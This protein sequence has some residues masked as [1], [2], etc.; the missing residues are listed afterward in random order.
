MKRAWLPILV[1]MFIVC[2]GFC[3]V[4]AIVTRP[5]SP[6]PLIV[7]CPSTPVDF[8]REAWAKFRALVDEAVPKNH[9]LTLK[10]LEECEEQFKRAFPKGLP[11]DQ[12]PA[13]VLATATGKK[14]QLYYRSTTGPHPVVEW[15]WDDK[16]D[17]SSFL[18]FIGECTGSK[19]LV[20]GDCYAMTWDW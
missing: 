11:L 2:G 8:D 6:V 5:P 18:L 10:R 16:L 7:N 9:D 12:I 14:K 17:G 1:V 3:M 19:Q 15:E 20:V 13:E 4:P